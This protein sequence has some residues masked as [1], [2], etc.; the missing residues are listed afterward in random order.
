MSL[1]FYVVWLD[2]GVGNY[3]GFMIVLRQRLTD[4]FVQNWHSRLEDSSRA[5]FSK[6]LASSQFQPYLENIN[7]YKCNAI[8]KLRLSSHCLEVEAGMWV[9]IDR[10]PA[11]ER[12]CTLCI[13]KEDV[14]HFVIECQRYTE[15]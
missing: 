10:V 8:S 7:G 2:Q 14:Y 11:I 13:V 12:K 5:L 3:K 6:S 1:G 4:N 9:R 15:L